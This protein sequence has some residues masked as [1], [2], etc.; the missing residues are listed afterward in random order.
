MAITFSAVYGVRKLN[1][2][3]GIA[4]IKY[5]EEGEHK[6]WLEVTVRQGPFTTRTVLANPTHIHL[7]GHYGDTTDGAFDNYKHIIAVSQ[8]LENGVSHS[9]P[10]IAPLPQDSHHDSNTMNWLFQLKDQASETDAL[11]NDLIQGDLADRSVKGGI[12]GFD[13]W[14]LKSKQFID[15][16]DK[17][18]D[19]KYLVNREKANA[20]L[21]MMEEHYGTEALEE[22]SSDE[23]Y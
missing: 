1:S 6:G 22:M 2:L 13:A 23:L 17:D 15:Y 3:N 9:D 16:A 18:L 10:I 11:F 20:T 4:Q 14:N 12:T 5:V 21:K 8:Y 7:A 19:K